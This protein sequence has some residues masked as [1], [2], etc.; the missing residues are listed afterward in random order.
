MKPN[1][2]LSNGYYSGSDERMESDPSE[3]FIESILNANQAEV[4][5]GPEIPELIVK[6][7]ERAVSQGLS[8]EQLEEF[9][10]K[11]K[12]PVN[13]KNL[14][15]PK[16][17]K[18]IWEPLPRSAQ[19]NDVSQQYLQQFLSK[20]VIAQAKT[21]EVLMENSKT[22]QNDVLKSLMTSVMDTANLIGTAI[23]EINMRRR[24]Q[25]R[26][27]LASESLGLCNSN[28]PVTEFLFGN[29]LEKDLSSSRAASKIVRQI[30]ANR[31]FNNFTRGRFNR[32]RQGQLR[33]PSSKPLNSRLPPNF[34]GGNRY[35]RGQ[36]NNPNRFQ[37]FSQ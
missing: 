23:R 14:G 27:H 18:E 5:F 34:R 32:G 31:G 29:N 30:G 3:I 37:R 6:A 10:K 7:L 13:A 25:V 16:V 22:I 1:Y 8:K 2:N 17:N 21:I 15:V 24:S 20:A 4:E 36:T 9:K 19:T 12:T 33:F 35:F 26:P 28:V 11:Y